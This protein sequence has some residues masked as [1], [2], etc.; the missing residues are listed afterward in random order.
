MLDGIQS[1][2]LSI[3]KNSVPRDYRLRK[4]K[5]L[6]VFLKSFEIYEKILLSLLIFCFNVNQERRVNKIRIAKL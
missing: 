6:Q 5:I 3:I 4:T 2:A 1:F